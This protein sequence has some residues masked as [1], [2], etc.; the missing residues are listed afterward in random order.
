MPNSVPKLATSST[1]MPR[2][3]NV[4]EGF[5]RI[6]VQDNLWHR[7]GVSF[8]GRLDT[9]NPVYN[10]YTP[11]NGGLNLIFGGTGF[12]IAP[13]SDLYVGTIVDAIREDIWIPIPACSMTNFYVASSVAPGG[14]E[15]YTFTVYKN[16][17]AQAMTAVI[18]GS[19]TSA[20]Y[21]GTIS[22]SAGD[23]FSVRVVTSSLANVAFLTYSVRIE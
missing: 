1:T 12:E 6:I 21:S 3:T 14:S 4:I 18:S 8:F 16:T 2:L 15:T 11:I 17:V 23:K 19:G 5:P 22:Y 20:S 7:S 10:T 13:G 9:E